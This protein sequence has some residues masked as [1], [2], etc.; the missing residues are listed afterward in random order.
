[1]QSSYRAVLAAGLVACLAVG[2]AMACGEAMYRMGGALRYQASVTHY[3]ANILIYASPTARKQADASRSD[4]VEHLT[5]AGHKV[6][7]VDNQQAL[8]QALASK[9]WDVVIAVAADL[10]VVSSELAKATRMP[11]VIPVMRHGDDE[12][13]R[14]QYPLAQAETVSANHM[15]RAIERTMKD[16]NS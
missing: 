11:A 5:V 8:D 1:M 4:L 15:L 7:L 16:R 10:P 14:Q 3:P 6:T 2:Q 13:V 12:S 9:S